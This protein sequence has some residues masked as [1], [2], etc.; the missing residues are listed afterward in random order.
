MSLSPY[1]SVSECLCLYLCLSGWR[2]LQAAAAATTAATAAATAAA[3]TAAADL[4]EETE[5]KESSDRF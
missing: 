5:A 2:F 3:A 1:G 4:K